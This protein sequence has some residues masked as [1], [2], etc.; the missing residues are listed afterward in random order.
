MRLRALL[1]MLF[2]TLMPAAAQT[3]GNS[4]YSFL[5]LSHSAYASATGGIRLAGGQGD[6]SLSY[7]NPALLEPIM[8]GHLSMSFS[9]WVAGLSYG[10]AAWAHHTESAGTFGAGV[11]FI[12]YGSFTAADETGLITGTFSA[13]EYAFNLMWSQQIDSSFRAGITLKPVLSHLERYF[14]AGICADLGINYHNE[15]LLFDAALVIRNAG[16]QL[17]RYTG[18]HREALPLEIAAGLSK[19]LAHAPFTFSL[20]LRHLEQPDMTRGLDA[21]DERAAG[22]VSEKVLRHMVLGVELHPSDLFWIGA[23]LNYQRRAEMRS[24]THA[25]MAGFTA[26]AGIRTATFELAYSHD[27]FHPAGGGNH[28]TLTLRTEKIF[29]KKESLNFNNGASF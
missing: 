23:G 14:S 15:P 4:I 9:T 18:E 5:N 10:H 20:T 28:I 13:A 29:K 2:L 26:G 6:L 25:G 17:K 3:G 8:D 27:A 11:S 21:A 24:D 16:I 19:Q 22:G 1:P 12:S 7:F